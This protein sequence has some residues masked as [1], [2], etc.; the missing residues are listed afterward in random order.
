MYLENMTISALV[1]NA[2]QTVTGNFGVKY[3]PIP[4]RGQSGQNSCRGGCSAR[5]GRRSAQ[6]R[7][8]QQHLTIQ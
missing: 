1:H 6:R 7:L 8:D 5:T 2:Q 4:G 3:K